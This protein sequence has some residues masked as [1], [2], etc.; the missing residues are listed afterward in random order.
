MAGGLSLDK[1]IPET[2]AR[3]AGS[4]LTSAN[5]IAAGTF[6]MQV[7]RIPLRR[8]EDGPHERHSLLIGDSVETLEI[9]AERVMHALD[10]GAPTYAP[11]LTFAHKAS[12][13]RISQQQ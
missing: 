4:A 3:F 13:Q 9:L 5:G 8:P 2:Q 6:S 1:L 10:D 12:R 7:N 11:A